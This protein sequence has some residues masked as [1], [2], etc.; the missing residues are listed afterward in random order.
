MF[1]APFG[2]LQ[3]SVLPKTMRLVCTDTSRFL[4]TGFVVDYNNH[5]EAPEGLH[6]ATREERKVRAVTI[7]NPR[8]VK[9]K[10]RFSK[11]LVLKESHYFKTWHDRAMQL[12]V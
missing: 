7:G 12:G 1:S 4:T 11:K 8:G 5:P 3:F 6:L 2:V 10:N 9:L